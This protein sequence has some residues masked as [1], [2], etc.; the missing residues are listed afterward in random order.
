M[1]S[2]SSGD[3]LSRRYRLC[4]PLG[5]GAMAVVYE[6]EDLVSGDRV[7]IKAL[8]QRFVSSPQ[9][10][11]RFHREAA[12]GQRL[13]HPNVVT[14]LGVS[15]DAGSPYLVME[16]LAGESLRARLR[17][18]GQCSVEVAVAVT[19]GVLDALAATH[20]EGIVHR[21][22]K[23]D[24]V[25][26]VEG[27]PYRVKVLDFGVSKLAV[28]DDQTKLSREGDLL[29][30]PGYMSPEQ[31]LN[32]AS[33]DA[34]C[35]LWAVGVL[36][37]EMLTGR[38]PYDA[39]SRVELFVEIA[40]GV[41]RPEPPSARTPGIDPA[42][43]A[44]V[45][46][47]LERDATRRPESATAMRD[48]LDGIM[49]ETVITREVAERSFRPPPRVERRRRWWMVLPVALAIAVTLAILASAPR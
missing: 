18:E 24:N 6:A 43:D 30:S 32:A 49:P 48:A 2:L 47:C 19:R 28:H 34:R 23:P 10:V 35:D 46:R 22:L 40:R 45:L 8:R 9:A 33:V 31:W 39:P 15:S 3:V 44:L 13:R 26:L 1:A 42:L 41:T 25:Y 12:V 38:L 14:C 27:D 21:D 4:R 5:S 20:A 7:A 37:Y 16:C 29:G 11:A 36:L 17:R